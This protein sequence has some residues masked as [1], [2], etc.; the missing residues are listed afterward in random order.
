MPASAQVPPAQCIPQDAII[1]LH[2]ARPKVLL[3]QLADEEM[4]QA[5]T[6]LPLYQQ[7][8]TNPEFKEF[9]NVI[10][11]L[12]TTLETNWR[13]ALAQLTGGGITLAVCPDD[14]VVA[15]VDAE[16]ESLLNRLHKIFVNIARSESQKQGDAERV[17]SR[18]YNG[19]TAWTFDGNEAHAIVG[20]RLIF[21][22]RFDTLKAALDLQAQPDRSSLERNP[23]F[24]AAR[25]AVQSDAVA[26]AFVNLKPLIGL[27]QFS[28]VLQ[29]PRTNPLAALMFAGITESL[30]S[31]SWLALNLGVHDRTLTLR[32]LTDG[33]LAGP[34]SPAAFALPQQPGDGAAP[35]I[36]VPR[37]IAAL[38][39]HRDLHAFYAAKDDLFPER[40]SGLIFFENMMGIFF[41]GRDLTSEVL[42]QTEPQIQ[43]VVAEQQYDPDIGT[44]QV[45]L[46][47][48]AVILRLRDPEQF[49]SVVEEAWQKAVGLINFTR[50][51]QALPGL[52][53]D[54]PTHRQTKFTLAYF[55][56]TD[57]T[58]K[59]KLDT[60][61]NISPSLALP[62]DYLV[63]SS[64][65][66]LARDLIDALGD[67]TDRQPAPLPQTHTLL[68]I[69]GTQLASVLQANRDTLVRQDMVKKGKTQQEAAAGIDMLI[70][71]LKGVNHA[72]LSIGTKNDLTQAALELKLD[73]PK[74]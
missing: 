54:R 12:E 62:G 71:L 33:K 40:T 68:E 6:A 20:K 31:S 4:I 44:P 7:Q 25:R 46:P 24:Q 42:A 64:T 17:A 35:G 43:L 49:G 66:G 63:L 38:S 18:Q 8:L 45:K 51:Q 32:A 29:K 74:P 47:A 3:E 30:R 16:D 39:L 69:S 21:A 26:T 65:D 53:I 70:T 28:E 56:T 73:L 52:I 19:I 23:T 13:T 22:N 72:E 14:T 10:E 11:F 37:R 36:A 59:T 57:V 27:P 50:G 41:T 48:F 2:L 34:D 61:F 5:I 58:D 1:C 9:L 67:A 15:V 55:S 60:R